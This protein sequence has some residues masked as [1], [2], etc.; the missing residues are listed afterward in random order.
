MLVV[1]GQVLAV[2]A[3]VGLLYVAGRMVV[4]LARVVMRQRRV[5]G[6][7]RLQ[8]QL[9]LLLVLLQQPGQTAAAAVAVVLVQ[10]L[11]LVVAPLLLAPVVH[12]RLWKVACLLSWLRGWWGLGGRCT[13][14]GCLCHYAR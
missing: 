1:R 5:Q 12:G 8:Q 10:L 6:E 3:V 4:E 2:A 13:W 11:L 7:H 9:N 14:R